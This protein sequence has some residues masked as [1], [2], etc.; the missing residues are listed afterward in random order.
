MNEHAILWALPILAAF[1]VAMQLYA[2][3]VLLGRAPRGWHYVEKSGEPR[4]YWLFLSA[5]L[6]LVL[7]L[8][9][10]AASS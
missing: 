10:Q 1:A 5:E 3:R 6:L 9:G 8:I 2:G 7:I 4:R